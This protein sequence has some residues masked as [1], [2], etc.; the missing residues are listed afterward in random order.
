MKIKS[1]EEPY[2]KFAEVYDSIMRDKFYKDYYNFVVKVLKQLKFKPKTILEVACGTGKLMQIFHKKGYKIE[3]V[4]LSKGMLDIARKKGLKVY[5]GNMVN[6][7]LKKRSDLILNIFDSLNYLQKLLYLEKCFKMTSRHLNRKGLF[8]FDMNSN[9]KIDKIIPKFKSE[10]YKVGD[11][12]LIW[13]NKYKSNTWIAEM[14]MFCK[15]NGEYTRFYEKHI[16]KAYKLN[17]IKRI[18]KKANFKLINTYSDFE[19][20]KVKKNSKRWFFIAKKM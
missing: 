16:E 8:I 1:N 19:F 11:T 12:E 15:N 4:D 9:F 17:E 20:N 18:L 10:Y 2:K 14:I 5:Q 6:F 13:L 3:G 7:N